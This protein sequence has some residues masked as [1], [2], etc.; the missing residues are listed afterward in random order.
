M[1]RA[2]DVLYVAGMRLLTG[3]RRIAGTRSSSDALVPAR[4]PRNPKRRARR[5]L[6]KW[7]QPPRAAARAR[8]RKRLQPKRRRRMPPTGSRGR[9]RS[10]VPRAAAAA[11]VARAGRAGSAFRR[12]RHARAG[13]PATRRCLRAVGRCTCCCSGCRG[14]RRRNGAGSR[15]ACLGASSPTI[16]SSLPNRSVEEAGAVLAASGARRSVRRGKPRRSGA[17]SGAFATERGRLCRERPDRPARC[18]RGR[19]AAPRFQDGPRRAG[20]AGGD[21]PGLR[22][23]DGALSPPSDGDGA[24]RPGG[25]TLV[26]TAGPNIMPIPARIAWKKRWRTLGVRAIRFL[27]PE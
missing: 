20:F 19:L 14:C 6:I 15:C 9:R 2:R 25:A 8:D 5:A 27:D 24:G 4:S 17:S 23:A 16:P 18:G 1:T 10:P 22:P 11:P 13:S 26:Y 12:R 7:P 21:R 3:R